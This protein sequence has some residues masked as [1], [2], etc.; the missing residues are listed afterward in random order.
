MLKMIVKGID[1]IWE[2]FS[3]LFLCGMVLFCVFWAYVF[4]YFFI[5]LLVIS[6][7]IWLLIATF[8]KRK[9]KTSL[10]RLAIYLV[11]FGIFYGYGQYLQ[12]KQIEAR[13]NVVKLI[14]QYEHD[15][16]KYP[17]REFINDINAEFSKY[18]MRFI[19]YLYPAKIPENEPLMKQGYRLSYRTM[20][21]TPFDDVVYHGN[22]EWEIIYD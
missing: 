11:I 14:Q 6:S 13:E 1:F 19:Y 20:L 3:T 22:N 5:V 17:E 10:I 7:L 18:Q 9:R 8:S 15:H 2:Y 12:M 21:L 16:G 4:S